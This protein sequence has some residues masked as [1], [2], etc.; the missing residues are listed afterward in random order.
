MFHSTCVLHYPKKL[1][2]ITLF[3][4]GN[5]YGTRLL[6]I[7]VNNGLPQR[8]MTTNSTIA[9]DSIKRNDE[10]RMSKYDIVA[11]TKAWVD[12]VVVDEKLC[13]FVAPLKEANAIRYVASDASNVEQAVQEFAVEAR[14]LVKD[15]VRRNHNKNPHLDKGLI[16]HRPV[17][18]AETV[19]SQNV[20]LMSFRGSFVDEFDDF[21]VLC[22][23]INLDV[24]I[25]MHFFD[26][27]AV[28]NFHP[29]YFSYYEKRHEKINDSIYYPRRSPFPTLL[30]VP[31]KDMQA[32]FDTDKV[33]ELCSGN[34]IKFVEQGLKKCKARLESCYLVPSK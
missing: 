15:R 19:T 24:I 30:L 13:P 14:L 7:E 10:I 23:Q 29:K 34:K 11:S 17:E 31:D 2:L 18:I 25:E 26:I 21:D 12:S 4:C 16:V 32:A 27:L 3:K 5:K 20:T 1:G 8:S 28:M 22:E 33:E 9:N 6:G